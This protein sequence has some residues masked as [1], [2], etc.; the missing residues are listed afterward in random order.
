MWRYAANVLV[1]AAIHR[2]RRP[3]R[4]LLL[5]NDFD[6]RGESGATTPDWRIA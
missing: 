3:Q 2:G 6:Q 1:D 5:E 4:H